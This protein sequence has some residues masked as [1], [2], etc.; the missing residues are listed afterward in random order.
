[1]REASD[2]QFDE[3]GNGK[4][5]VRYGDEDEIEMEQQERKRRQMLNREFRHFADK[6]VE[7]ASSSV[8]LWN[9]S[10]SVLTTD[11]L[12]TGEPLE[13][14]IPFRELLFEG[15]PYHTNVRP[16]PSTDFEDTD[17]G[18]DEDSS[19]GD[20]SDKGSISPSSLLSEWTASCDDW[21]G[22]QMCANHSSQL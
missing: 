18:S 1:M 8:S 6:I 7:A 11:F 21:D 2:V 22:S 15:A 10:L 3:T 13:M 12:Q 16:Q 19:A 20:L 5:N 14:G 4:Q 17:S 9:S